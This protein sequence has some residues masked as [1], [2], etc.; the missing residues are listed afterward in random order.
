M[1]TEVK[2]QPIFPKIDLSGSENIPLYDK[3]IDP[4]NNPEAQR[5]LGD[6]N[7]FILTK[8][9]YPVICKIIDFSE[10]ESEI[11]IL[12]EKLEKML[13][14]IANQDSCIF[15]TKDDISYWSDSEDNTVLSFSYGKREGG[16]S[17]RLLLDEQDSIFSNLTI[18]IPNTGDENYPSSQN[19]TASFQRGKF[20]EP[21]VK[22]EYTV[23]RTARSLK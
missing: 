7:L 15:K 20:V 23:L 18:S 10:G 12:N 4:F 2:N 5:V 16:W 17:V 9:V 6:Q 8:F 1:N 22:E 19:I 14:L 21:E 13:R 3:G 11:N